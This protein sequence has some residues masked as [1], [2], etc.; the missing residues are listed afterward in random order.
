M[1]V[2]D[3]ST[4]SNLDRLRQAPTRVSGP[5]LIRALERVKEIRAIGVENLNLSAIPPNR[6]RAIARYAACASAQT[7]SRMAEDRKIATLLA[8]SIVFSTTAMD[9]ALEV[10][11]LLITEVRANAEKTGK[12]NRLRT[13]GDLDAAALQ[14]LTISCKL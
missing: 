10:L 4:Q 9:D 14:L 3:D 12:R 11:D 5:G 13:I 7:I 2:P 8:F 6:L 1:L